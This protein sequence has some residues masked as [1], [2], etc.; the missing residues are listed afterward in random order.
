MIQ[1]TNRLPP[2]L[3]RQPFVFYIDIFVYFAW[4]ANSTAFVVV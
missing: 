4:R 2:N 3:G 1:K